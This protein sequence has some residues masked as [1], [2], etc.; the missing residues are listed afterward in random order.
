MLTAGAALIIGSSA[1]DKAS[2]SNEESGVFVLLSKP[3]GQTEF[4]LA[5]RIVV[6]KDTFDS[7]IQTR[8]EIALSTVQQAFKYFYAG[9]KVDQL[10]TAQFTAT[11]MSPNPPPM[12]KNERSIATRGL[13]FVS[14]QNGLKWKRRPMVTGS[15]VDR[16]SSTDKDGVAVVKGIEVIHVSKETVGAWLFNLTSNERMQAHMQKNGNSLRSATQ[17]FGTHTSVTSVEVS[18]PLVY[19]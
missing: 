8:A 3:F 12:S 19:I 13:Y 4:T 7:E 18:L 2:P 1:A 16:F 14:P 17:D 15:V 5:V 10:F 9:E 11:V 6:S